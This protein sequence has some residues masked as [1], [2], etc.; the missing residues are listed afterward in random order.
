MAVGCCVVMF[1]VLWVFPPWGLVAGCSVLGVVVGR[2]LLVSLVWSP[3]LGPL[4]CVCL[5]GGE[6]CRWRS[7]A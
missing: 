2:L 1:G 6:L 7:S 5:C 4:W 3:W